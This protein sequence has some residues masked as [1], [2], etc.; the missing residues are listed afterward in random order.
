MILRDEVTVQRR[1]LLPEPDEYG[2]DQY[3][4]VEQPY[5]AEV[6]PLGSSETV[7]DRQTVQSRYRLFLPASAVAISATDAVTWR[8]IE[9]EL[10]GDVEPHTLGRVLHHCEVIAQR[11]TG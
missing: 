1:V 9:L 4:D 11:V 8:G 7:G 3:E 2:N 5:A 6:R 10:Q